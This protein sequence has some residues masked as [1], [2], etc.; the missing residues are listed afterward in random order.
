MTATQPARRSLATRIQGRLRLTYRR[1]Q[2]NLGVW[3][4]IRAVNEAARQPLQASKQAP[5]VFFNATTRLVGISQNAA[6]ALLTE[7]GLQLAGTPVVNFVCQAGL[8]RCVLGTVSVAD[9]VRQGPPCRACMAQSRWLLANA[10]SLPFTYQED[11]ALAAALQNLSVEQ[12]CAFEYLAGALEGPAAMPAMIPLGTL[13]QPSIRWALRRHHL[14]DDEPTRWLLRA[15]MISA[16]NV[17]RQFSACLARLEPQAVVVFNGMQ[18]PEATAR[19]V[20]QGR[21]VKAITFEAGIQPFTAFFTRGEAT[22]Y[23]LPIPDDFELDAAQNTRLEAYLAQRAQGQFSMAGVRF[24]T[25]IDKLDDA[26]LQKA[27]GF[28]QIVPV[29]TNVIFDTSQPHANVVF[30]HMFAWLDEVLAIA[31][32]HPETLFVIRAHPDEIRPGKASRES[33]AQWAADRQITSLPNIVFVESSQ[34]LSSYELIQRS[35]F[36][37]IY[38]STIGLEAA[39]LGAAVL[40]AGKSR[41]THLPIVFF[42]RSIPAFQEQVEA[43]LAPEKIDVPL[44]FARNARRF[45]Y[46]QLHFS[47]LPFG[48]YLEEDGVWT[49]FV[50]LRRFDWRQLRAENS[51]TMRTIIKGVLE[52]GNFLLEKDPQAGKAQPG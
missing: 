22:A 7:L 2:N 43:M 17:A 3:R 34:K 33:V 18:Y 21:G 41:F 29:F 52:D 37:M 13:V 44:E 47:S 51:A 4:L 11:P 42:P 30:P 20:A 6:F 9:P 31:R 28:R 40:C 8:S 46:Y 14:Q 5:V 38:N 27:A 25:G 19:W 39:I 23:P 36:V 26:F 1:L 48:D 49:G 45:L 50:R 35:K 16:W 32:R 10:P 15:Y 12:L 24:W